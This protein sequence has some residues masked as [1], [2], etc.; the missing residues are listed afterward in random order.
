MCNVT[1]DRKRFV[2]WHMHNIILNRTTYSHVKSR[3]HTHT[4]QK[5]QTARE[6]YMYKM[7]C[8][9]STIFAVARQSFTFPCTFEWNACESFFLFLSIL[10]TIFAFVFV[11]QILLRRLFFLS[12]FLFFVFLSLMKASSL[13]LFAVLL[14]S[15][16]YSLNSVCVCFP[17]FFSTG[18]IMMIS[19][20][21]YSAALYVLYLCMYVC[22]CV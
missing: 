6:E 16:L 11:V 19:T 1:I 18:K 7:C 5:K 8:K 20:M 12:F 9:R 17:V 13:Y 3:T 21:S 14:C 15:K 10:F 4:H 2:F 22:V